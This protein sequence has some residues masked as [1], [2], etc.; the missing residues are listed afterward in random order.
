MHIAHCTLLILFDSHLHFPTLTPL[1]WQQWRNAGLTGGIGCTAHRSEW[2]L[3]GERATLFPGLQFAWG[4]H[5]WYAREVT[6]LSMDE[7]EAKLRLC[8]DLQIGEIGLDYAR[9]H[10]GAPDRLTQQYA[11]EEQLKLAEKYTRTAILHIRKAWDD[12]IAIMSRH[13]DAKIIIHSFSGSAEIASELLKRF[14]NCRLSF[15]S[16]LCNDNAE[17]LRAMVMTLPP[18]RVLTDSDWQYKDGITPLDCARIGA[19]LPKV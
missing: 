6:E 13:H 8:D 9:V 19:L 14:P 5:P 1:Q 10:Y 17:R 3:P 7:L 16:T 12:F 2:R 4:I 15:G 11:F 18:E